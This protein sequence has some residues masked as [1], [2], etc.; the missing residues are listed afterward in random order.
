MDILYLA[1]I[2]I[3]VFLV[4]K[5]FKRFVRSE[6][7]QSMV[8]EWHHLD[9]LSQRFDSNELDTSYV[10]FIKESGMDHIK[11]GKADDPEQRKKELSTGSAHTHE[12]VHLIKSKKP[13]KTENLFHS[14]FHDKRFK[15]EWFDLTESELRW[16]QKENYPREIEDSIKGY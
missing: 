13:Y 11:I 16:I 15:G 14:Y 5:A 8:K 9:P 4:Y 3:I 12:I 10:Y 7:K 1:S 2:T 6:T